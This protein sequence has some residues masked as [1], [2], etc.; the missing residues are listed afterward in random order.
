MPCKR[1]LA[2]LM[3]ILFCLA[4]PA[5]TASAP[6]SDTFDTEAEGLVQVQTVSIYAEDGD[7]ASLDLVIADGK[8]VKTCAPFTADASTVYLVPQGCFEAYIDRDS[9]RVLNRLVRVAVTDENGVEA[10]PP[11]IMDAVFCAIARLEHDLMTVKIFDVDGEIFV[12]AEKNVNLWIP[13]SLYY[14]DR[15]DRRLVELYTFDGR[16]VRSLHVLSA[17][18]LH[19][20]P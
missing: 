19:S 12:Y 15:T 20:L 14:F 16:E 2:A 18:R 10:E 7:P 13:C 6:F 1:P 4:A 5:C 3:C 9:N 11:E 8:R 17:D